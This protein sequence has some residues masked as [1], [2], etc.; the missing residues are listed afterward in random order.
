MT[1]LSAPPAASGGATL[2]GLSVS[3]RGKLQ[4]LD[5]LV[6]AAVADVERFQDETD[7]G[8]RIFIK[9]LVEM[10]TANLRQESRHM[11]SIADLCD[12][13]DAMVQ[14]PEAPAI[15]AAGDLS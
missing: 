9:Q 4:F 14:S 5:Y 11:D 12:M 7:P 6:R 13:L 3:I 1:Q 8:T 2:A 15:F 10:H